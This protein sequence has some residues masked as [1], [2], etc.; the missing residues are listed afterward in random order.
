MISNQR[1]LKQESNIPNSSNHFEKHDEAFTPSSPSQK[2]KSQSAG[3]SSGP[4][5]DFDTL[6]SAPIVEQIVNS[7]QTTLLPRIVE[8]NTSEKNYH[9][10]QGSPLITDQHSFSP[11]SRNPQSRFGDFKSSVV[12]SAAQK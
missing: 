12:S 11:N 10:A 9:S 7:G 5:V 4:L 3:G 2:S 6:R 8:K 1:S